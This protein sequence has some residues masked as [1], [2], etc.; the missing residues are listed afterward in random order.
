MTNSEHG[1]QASAFV[2]PETHTSNIIDQFER[3]TKLFAGAKG[4]H[5]GEII[6]AL[7]DA[8]A[9]VPDDA[10]LDVAC[11]PGTVVAA[12]ATHVG[13]A[14]GVDVTQSMLDEAASLADQRGLENVEWVRGDAMELPFAD[15]S[16]DVVS[17]RFA[18]HHMQNP[19][20]VLSEMK[21]VCRIGGRV[22]VCDAIASDDPV[23]AAALN[24]MERFRDS[25]TVSFRPL[26]EMVD[27]FVAG[28]MGSPKVNRFRLLSE[29]DGLA[30]ISFPVDD[31]REALC[32]M[33]DGSV[34]GD[35]MGL[36]AYW[37]GGTVRFHYPSAILVAKRD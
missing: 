20:R 10:T 25:S 3:Q 4:L 21:R 7:V 12:F 5:S 13:R 9:P 29:R 37:H 35:T 2:D 8:A 34:E 17:C 27:Y 26:D 14:V 33:I 22:V 28:G 1:V 23:K 15:K 6:S 19:Q 18:F 31:D 32:Q 30:R 24:K 11:G 16:F 36:G